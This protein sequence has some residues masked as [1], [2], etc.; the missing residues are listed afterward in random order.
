MRAPARS[1]FAG[2]PQGAFAG[3]LVTQGTWQGLQSLYNS[4]GLTSLP[5]T[6]TQL[7]PC[8]FYEP[9]LSAGRQAES[10]LAVGTVG[11][12]AAGA[13]FV[14]GI[15]AAWRSNSGFE[16]PSLWASLAKRTTSI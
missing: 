4:R 12:D 16:M 10:G 8:E 13:D 5:L 3:F 2:R 1:A 9:G 15:C 7:E 6:L 11:A 14:T